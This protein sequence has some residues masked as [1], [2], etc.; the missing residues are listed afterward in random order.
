[1]ARPRRPTPDAEYRVTAQPPYLPERKTAHL[2]D[3]LRGVQENEPI[4]TD[5]VLVRSHPLPS[6]G[7]LGDRHR[8]ERLSSDQVEAALALLERCADRK[9]KLVITGVGKSGIVAR[10]IAA[11]FSRSG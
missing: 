3:P 6:G 2:E 5:T 7:S 8:H 4:I 1:M 9:A 11:T 10:K